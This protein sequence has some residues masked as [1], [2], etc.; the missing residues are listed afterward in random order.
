MPLVRIIADSLAISLFL[1]RRNSNKKDQCG[2]HKHVQEV[3]LLSSA[4]PRPLRLSSSFSL[5]NS[6][7]FLHMWLLARQC[8]RSTRTIQCAYCTVCRDIPGVP[9]QHYTPDENAFGSYW[10]A[11]LCRDGHVQRPAGWSATIQA[12][13]TPESLRHIGRRGCMWSPY[14]P[15]APVSLTTRPLGRTWSPWPARSCAAFRKLSS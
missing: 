10:S 5:R 15:D 13:E 1:Q 2:T 9:K 4:Q 12:G 14:S 7:Y 3:G 6:Y 11:K 8:V